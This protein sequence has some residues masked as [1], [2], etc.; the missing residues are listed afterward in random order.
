MTRGNAL[1]KNYRNSQSYS[2]GLP[3]KSSAIK[4]LVV[5][6]KTLARVSADITDIR[7]ISRVLLGDDVNL[8]PLFLKNLE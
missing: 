1:A 2:I 6:R 7:A 5:F 8:P 3:D 4:G